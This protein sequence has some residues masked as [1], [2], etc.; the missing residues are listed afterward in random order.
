MKEM[1]RL[2]GNEVRD[3][4]LM[5]YDILSIYDD[6][7]DKYFE[8]SD[9]NISNIIVLKDATTLI[10]DGNEIFVNTSGNNGLATGGS[11]DVLTGIIAGLLAQG[12]NNLEAS[13]LGVYLHGLCA[14]YYTDKASKYALNASDLIDSLQYIL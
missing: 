7:E 9:S 11:G 14:E 10:T 2:M 6:V 1:S 3:V 13:A 5:Q 8:K 4:Q 12:K